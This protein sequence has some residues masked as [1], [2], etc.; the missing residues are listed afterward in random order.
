MFWYHTPSLL[1]KLNPTVSPLCWCC[2]FSRGTQFHLFWECSGNTECFW[3]TVNTL[4]HDVLGIRFSL[5]LQLF[6]LNVS[7]CPIGAMNLRIHML[8]AARCLIALFWK[9]STTPTLLDLWARIKDVRLLEYMM[10]LSHN[11]ADLFFKVWSPWDLY[12]AEHEA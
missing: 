4:L 11:K 1:N 5:D 3:N 7:E 10:A 12:S 9:R 8:T 2:G 6:L